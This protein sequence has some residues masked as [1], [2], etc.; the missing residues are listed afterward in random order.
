MPR[1]I[2]ICVNA[3]MPLSS[4]P[5][6]TVGA[7]RALP[8]PRPVEGSSPAH[9]VPGEPAALSSQIRPALVLAEREAREL[10]S[11]AQRLDVARG[12]CFHAG[13]AGIQV[14]SRPFDGPARFPGDEGVQWG[15]VAWT[16]DTPARHYA[17]IYRCLV[18]AAGLADGESTA[19]I[20]ARVLALTGLPVGG[21]RVR[22]AAPP[23]RD[24]FRSPSA[25]AGDCG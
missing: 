6:A 14:W 18:T 2:F 16:Y 5:G 13:V 23:I 10:L 20:L 17:T 11:A 4:G 9:P 22:L 21:E 15:Y 8:L 24:P 19:S 1:S 7:P 12:G 25:P 3:G